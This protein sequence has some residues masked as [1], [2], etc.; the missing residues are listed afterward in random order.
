MCK[1]CI[2]EYTR[3]YDEKNK[4]KKSERGNKYY[5]DNKGK[6]KQYQIDNKETIKKRSQ[7][8]YQKNKEKITNRNKK[9]CQDNEEK[10]K[11]RR[12]KN[13]EGKR[14]RDIERKYNLTLIDYNDMLEKQNNK[15]A[16]CGK[17]LKNVIFF[18]Y[19]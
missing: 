14:I 2:R 8:Y 9:Y 4:K 13:K 6:L 10:L 5:Q 16:I 7:E 15:C 3:K 11:I 12:E 19:L 1:I 18:Q 17:K